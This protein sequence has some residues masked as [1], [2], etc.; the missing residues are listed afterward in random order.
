MTTVDAYAEALRTPNGPTEFMRAFETSG[1][2][3]PY[4]NGIRVGNQQVQLNGGMG[5]ALSPP[6]TNNAGKTFAY[7]TVYYPSA[8]T[9]AEATPLTVVPGQERTGIDIQ[10]R[11]VQTVRVSG[12]VTGPEGA[13]QNIGLKLL[14]GGIESYGY[15][16]GFETGATAS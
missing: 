3:P 12:V 15:D 11:T 9:V 10:V 16:T 4:S 6:S 14:P 1:M 5:R 7:A 2:P 8:A 13:A